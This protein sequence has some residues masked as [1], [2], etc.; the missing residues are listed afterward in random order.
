M[1]KSSIKLFLLFLLGFVGAMVFLKINFYDKDIELEQKQKVLEMFV[2]GMQELELLDQGK[3]NQL[4]VNI[5]KNEVMSVVDC[6]EFMDSVIV[7]HLSDLPL[8]K[9]KEVFLKKLQQFDVFKDLREIYIQKNPDYQ[10]FIVS[11]E[12]EYP[13][14]FYWETKDSSYSRGQQFDR[15]EIDVLLDDYLKLRDE[16]L[17]IRAHSIKDE[18]ADSTKI[19]ILLCSKTTVEKVSLLKKIYDFN[20][21]THSYPQ[22]IRSKYWHQAFESLENANLI[23]SQSSAKK[24]KLVQ[25]FVKDQTANFMAL[26]HEFPELFLNYNYD[27]AC[28]TKMKAVEY[29]I[30]KLS[31]HSNKKFNPTSI[32]IKKVPKDTEAYSDEVK[33]IL[34][35][36]LDKKWNKVPVVFEEYDIYNEDYETIG[37]DYQI[38]NFEEIVEEINLMIEDTSSSAAGQFYAL[39]YCRIPK[40]IFLSNTQYKKVNKFMC[41]VDILEGAFDCFCCDYWSPSYK[42]KNIPFYKKLGLSESRLKLYQKDIEALKKVLAPI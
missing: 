15:F 31:L 1:I 21:K 20:L 4:L 8:E 37:Y 18:S 39:E 29:L 38:T 14:Y 11:E 41:F 35:F 23:P 34:K 26:Y 27:S 28:H 5:S 40:V 19:A 12:P 3:A 24:D 25:E 9:N 33:E 6:F 13:Y 32:S 2:L 36:K 17:V 7:F 30:S 16:R 10:T 22:I 42:T